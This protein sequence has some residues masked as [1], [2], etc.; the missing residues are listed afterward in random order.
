MDC[1]LYVRV[2]TGGREVLAVVCGDASMLT[3]GMK[4]TPAAVRLGG[5]A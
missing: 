2:F 1:C 5:T 4:V 3:W